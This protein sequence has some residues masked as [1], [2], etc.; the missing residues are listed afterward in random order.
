LV[1]RRLMRF[2]RG[3]KVGKQIGNAKLRLACDQDYRSAKE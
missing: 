3:M 2:A 1:A